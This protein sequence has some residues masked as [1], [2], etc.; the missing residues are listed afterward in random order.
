MKIVQR[1][2]IVRMILRGALLLMCAGLFCACAFS[3]RGSA[4]ELQ[5]DENGRLIQIIVEKADKTLDINDLEQYVKEQIDAFNGAA[6]SGEEAEAS[7]SADSKS[8]KT[9]RIELESCKLKD[10]SVQIRISYAGYED[11]MQFNGTRCFFG[12]IAEAEE[13]GYSFDQTWL[14]EKGKEAE[15]AKT[16]I[17]E[18][19]AEWKVLIAEEPMHLRVPDKILYTSQNLKT[20]GR[21]TA[22]YRGSAEKKDQQED[23]EG[24]DDTASGEVTVQDPELRKFVID[25]FDLSYVIFK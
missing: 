18:R 25:D 22:E 24:T 20:T 9:G 4:T 8:S 11:Y 13:A 23:A 3:G 5:A 2:V 17:S 14:N 1:H 21:M 10:G 15:D 12:T 7:S 19:A 6:A 16:T